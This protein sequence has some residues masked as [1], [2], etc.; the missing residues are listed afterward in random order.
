MFLMSPPSSLRPGKNPVRFRLPQPGWTMSLCGPMPSSLIRKKLSTQ[1]NWPR[2][3]GASRLPL[4]VALIPGKPYYRA[5]DHQMVAT[6]LY[7]GHAQP[8]GDEAE[9]LF[10]V[11]EVVDCLTVAPREAETGC[12]MKWNI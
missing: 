9:D 4:D 10:H 3:L 11:D 6:S 1:S 2:R 12:M 8:Q 5:A 7:V